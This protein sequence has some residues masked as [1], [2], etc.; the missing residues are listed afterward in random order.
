MLRRKMYYKIRAAGRDLL[1]VFL[2]Y[3][4]N[5]IPCWSI[6]K[7]C[8]LCMGMKIGHGTRICMKCIIVSPWNI[9]IGNNTMINEYVL[10]DGRGT[11][12]IGDSCSLSMWSIVY[13]ASHRKDSASFQYYERSTKI[14][15]CCWLGSRSV[16][17]PGSVL[18]DRTIISVNSTFKGLSQTSG[19]YIGNP[20]KL[21]GFRKLDCNYIQINH[22]YF[23]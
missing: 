8:Y 3:F 10:L 6:R 16:I 18:Q 9:Q 22:N 11:L 21:E 13:T 5:Y 1:Y 20:A 23:K 14:G 17:M 15:S 4:V 12:K 7:L 19:I 2:N